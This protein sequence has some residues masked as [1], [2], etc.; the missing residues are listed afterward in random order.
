MKVKEVQI[1]SDQ[2]IE[3]GKTGIMEG[4]PI[5]N[6]PTFSKELGKKC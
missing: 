2:S 4:N 6:P 1:Y 3:T 5:Q